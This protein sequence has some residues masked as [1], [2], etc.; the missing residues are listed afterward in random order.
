[1]SNRLQHKETTQVA[2]DC[3]A[4]SVLIH[5]CVSCYNMCLVKIKMLWQ[6][7]CLHWTIKVQNFENESKDFNNEVNDLEFGNLI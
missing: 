5:P 7:E 2:A 4:D 6:P 1:M 3:L